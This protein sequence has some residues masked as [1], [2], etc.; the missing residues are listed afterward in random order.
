[1]KMERLMFEV[2]AFN[3]NGAVIKA[4]QLEDLISADGFAAGLHVQLFSR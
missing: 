1:M 4:A 3:V 2:C